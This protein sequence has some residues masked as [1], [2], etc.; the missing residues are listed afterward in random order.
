MLNARTTLL[1]VLAMAAP[2]MANPVN[3]LYADTPPCDTHGPRFAIEELG[4]A[5][6][7]PANELIDSAST[8]TQQVAC[9]ATD[10]PTIPNALVVITNLTGTSWTDLFYVADPETFFSNEDGLAE[11]A[12]APGLR[13]QAM[14]IDALGSNRNLVFESI[15][16]DGIFD[17]G[18]TW[19][20]IVQD[21]SNALGAAPS[22]FTSLDFAG[23][24]AGPGVPGLAPS[25]ASIVQ[26]VVP[27]PSTASLLGL[28]A[29]VGFRRRRA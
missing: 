8:F 13:T 3:G 2:A 19:H 9:P 17:P 21:Y 11:S 29:L 14:R 28:G 20:F 25:S 1:A 16:V 7:F 5:P 23:A 22:S 26:M 15:A 10:N 12:A 24:S 6:L 18:E 4:N 27:S